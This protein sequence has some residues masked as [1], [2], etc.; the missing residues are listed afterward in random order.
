MSSSKF[1]PDESDIPEG[2]DALELY[3][4]GL[5]NVKALTEQGILLEETIANR[6]RPLRELNPALHE[7][8]IYQSSNQHV[9]I[10]FPMTRTPCALI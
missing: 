1:L 9:L 3:L 2:A 10:A 4:S 7:L 6:K 8:S 5:I